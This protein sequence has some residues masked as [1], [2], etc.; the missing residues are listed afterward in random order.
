MHPFH[1]KHFNLNQVVSIE[2]LDRLVHA[3]HPGTGR[4]SPWYAFEIRFS[5]GHI[6]QVLSATEQENSAAHAEFLAALRDAGI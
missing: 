1:G 5:N 4:E 2:L 3:P 6:E